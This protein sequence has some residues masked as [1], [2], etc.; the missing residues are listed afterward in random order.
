M[1]I[2]NGFVSN[3][4]SSSFVIY[5]TEL[6]SNFLKDLNDFGKKEL[7]KLLKSNSWYN[8]QG[9][10]DD[11]EA[12]KEYLGKSDDVDLFNVESEYIGTYIGDYMIQ[13]YN[14]EYLVGRHWYTIKDDETGKQFKDS[15]KEDF[16]KYFDKDFEYETFDEVNYC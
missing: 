15:V 6:E 8:Y 3:S 14:N 1:K 16:K 2:R 5:G 4:S 9:G 10:D 7:I 13:E 12:L 11:F